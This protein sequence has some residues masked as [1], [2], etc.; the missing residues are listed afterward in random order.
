MAF[1]RG[2]FRVFV[3][4]CA[5]STRDAAATRQ[6]EA[7]EKYDIESLS[8][9]DIREDPCAAG[10]LMASF[11]DSEGHS[12]SWVRPGNFLGRNDGRISRIE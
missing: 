11:V 7:L 4:L 5:F 3:G 12:Y 1:Q 10:S 6:L 9:H 8:I 2:A